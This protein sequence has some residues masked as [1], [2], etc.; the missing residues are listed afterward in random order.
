MRINA[1]IALLLGVLLAGC[2]GIGIGGEKSSTS[3]LENIR[4]GTEGMVISFLTTYPKDIIVGGG[5]GTGST[6]GIGEDIIFTLRAENRGA[7][8]EQGGP[9]MSGDIWLSGYDPRVIT[10]AEEPYSGAIASLGMGDLQLYGKTPYGPVG[11]SGI[12]DFKG[13]INMDKLTEGKYSP[14][15]LGNA[16]YYYETAAQPQICIEKEPL[17]LFVKKACSAKDVS[18]SSQGAPVAVTKVEQLST[19]SKV[20]FKITFKNVGKGMVINPKVGDC[21]KDSVAKIQRYDTD[22]I[23]IEEVSIAGSQL[24]CSGTGTESAEKK[25]VH[26]LD[27]TGFATCSIPLADVYTG[28]TP[29]F[30]TPLNIRVSYLYKETIQ[31]KVN[32][33]KIG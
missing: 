4:Q 20:Q 30:A 19:P 22:R 25:V 32:I 13:K 14:T 2:T 26:L 9:G 1:G 29:A 7:Y 10:F 6:K 17:A 21:K 3:S 23:Q 5:E 31:Q 11:D 33:A 15:I 18:L 24:A 27:G 16:C 12:I 8:P 28:T